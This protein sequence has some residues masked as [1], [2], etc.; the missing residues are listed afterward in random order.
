MRFQHRLR[1]CLNTLIFAGCIGMFIS[2]HYPPAH[3]Q[4]RPQP[5]DTDPAAYIYRD[6]DGINHHLE[7]TDS[8]VLNNNNQIWAEIRKMDE[9]IAGFKGEERGW[10]A[11]LSVLTALSILLPWLRERE[12]KRNRTTP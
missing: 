10:G 4:R 8:S 1:I 2:G 11:G 9:D 7:T 12:A 3:A 6:I 5:T